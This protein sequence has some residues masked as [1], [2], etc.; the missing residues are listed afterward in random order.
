MTKPT[1]I[2][3]IPLEFEQQPCDIC[4]VAMDARDNLIVSMVQVDGTWRILSR[5]GDDR[6][7]CSGSTTNRSAC[8]NVMDFAFAPVAFRASLKAVLFRYLRRGRIGSRRPGMTSALSLFNA[9]LI[10]LRHLSKLNLE[11]LGQVTPMVCAVYVQQLKAVVSTKRKKPLAPQTIFNL[12]RAVEAIHELS[13][14]TDDPMPTHPWADSS[15]YR[16]AGLTRIVPHERQTGKTPLM[17]DE[18]FTRLFQAAWQELS[19]RD[20]LLNLRDGLEIIRARGSNKDTLHAQHQYLN[21]HGWT[22]GVKAFNAE[23]TDLRTAC[24]IVVASLSG[25]RNHELAYV[26]TDACYSTEDEEGEIYWWMRSQSVKTHE[27]HTE[28]MIPEAA[29][30]ALKTMDRWAK[31]FQALIA[32]EI[33]RRRAVD[34]TDPEIAEAQR[35]LNAVF[36]GKYSNRGNQVRTL[37]TAPCNVNLE[38]FAKKHC[39]N[40][41]VASHQFRRKFANYAARSQ[42]GDLR[43]LKEHFKHWSM[44]M[45]LGYAL[46]ESQEMALYAEIQEELDGL[47][48]GA[49]AQWLDP[50]EPLAGGLG[51]NMMS[52]RGQHDVTLFKTQRHMIRSLSDSV[53]IRSSGHGWCTADDNLC[54]GNGGLDRT[55]CTQCSHAVI[56]RIHAHIYQGLYDQLKTVVLCQ[57]IGEG[58]LARVRRDID[59]CRDV[60]MSLG[61]DPE[62]AKHEQAAA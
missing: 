9:S 40:W 36:L 54:I 13:Q 6:W 23:I 43:Y 21:A 58:G 31:P 4:A 24:Y 8:F 42:F 1:A 52:W 41:K 62:G 51:R 17:P 11:R 59:R 26:Q 50:A 37:S 46:N 30:V 48:D 61:Y 33:K 32:D 53:A 19:Q 28:W 56:G 16:L 12:L 44:D 2:E 15:A 3:R 45:T 27:G 34:P 60:L 5:F 14:F 55:R 10:F 7:K 20:R 18:V 29:V 49:V 22:A 25:C 47:K 57:D 38:W 39:I 35:H